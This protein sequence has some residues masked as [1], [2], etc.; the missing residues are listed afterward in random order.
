MNSFTD[1][2][3]SYGRADSRDFA[4]EVCDRLTQQGYRV[5]Y[6]FNDIPPGVDYQK[7]IHN[8]IE[9]TDNFL[10]IISP[11]ATNSPHCRAEIDYAVSLNKR[12]VPIMH[13]EEIDQE[14]WQ[15]RHPSGTID[16]WNAYTAAGKQLCYTNLHSA[17]ANINWN[18]V[19]FRPG[20]DDIEQS[21]QALIE[22]FERRRDYVHHHT[23]LLSQ[24]LEWKRNQRQTQYLLIGEERQQAEAWL[25]ERFKDE[26]A[27]CRPT[28]L[29][30][31]FIT[32]SIKNANNLMTQVFLCH[33]EKDWEVAETLRRSLMR[34]GITTWIHHNDIESASDFHTEMK[35]GV[36]E[37]DNVVFLL[38][39]ASLESEYCQKELALA[40]QLNKRI[41]PIR[42]KPVTSEQIPDCL[43]NLQYIDFVNNLTNTDYKVDENDLL[44]KL[45]ENAGFYNEHKVL[46]AKA[47][48]WE[49]QHHN[50]CILLRGYELQSAQAWLKVAKKQE[51]HDPIPLQEQFITE[52]QHQ[53][54]GLSLDIFVSYSRTDSDFAR[55]LNDELQ[56]Q[57]KRTWF[58]QESIA[59][60]ADF[61]KE[62][63]RGI[64]ASDHFLFVL[65]P[66]SVTSRYCA[67]EVEYAAKL[68][69]NIVT[70][71][72]QG[73]D[74]DK[75][76]SELSKIQWI[77][78]CANNRDFATNFQ[79]LVRTLD[80]DPEHLRF[81][82]KLLTQAIAWDE[83]KRRES[84]LLRGDEL[85]DAEQW[86][87]QATA[88]QP[89]PTKLQSLY[90]TASRQTSANRQRSTIAVLTVLLGFAALG[91]MFGFW[92]SD[93]ASRALAEANAAKELAEQEQEK[94]KQALDEANDQRLAAEAAEREAA[95]SQQAESRQRQV[96]ESERER[97]ENA[98]ERAKE[99]ELEAN[100]QAA[101]AN[102][103][104]AIAEKNE[105]AAVIASRLAE[106]SVDDARQATRSA[107]MQAELSTVRNLAASGLTFQAWLR[108][109][110]IGRD[111]QI[112]ETK[113]QQTSNARDE[114]RLK[115]SSNTAHTGA[116]NPSIRVQAIALLREIVHYSGYLPHTTLQGHSSS[117]W[118]LDISPDGQT[119]ASAS[120]DQ[121]VK[122]WDMHGQEQ[123]TLEGHLAPINRVSF[124]PN[125]QTLATGS[126]DGTVKLWTPTGEELIT[127]HAHAS[128]VYGIKFSADGQVLATAS[129]DGSVKLWDLATI[130]QY[131][132]TSLENSEHRLSPGNV[133]ERGGNP[134]YYNEHP[135][136]VQ[137]GQELSIRLE[138]NEFDTYLI[139]QNEDGEVISEN[140][141]ADSTTV[142][143]QLTLQISEDSTYTIMATSYTPE[144]TGAYTFSVTSLPKAEITLREHSASVSDID[145]SP[146]DQTFVT[147]SQDGT[148]SL[149]DRAGNL[150]H[151]FTG[152][153][154]GIW[155]V[156]F[157]PDG[158]TLAT[159]S[160]DGAVK[161][162]DVAS[163][164]ESLSFQ[165]HESSIYSI[166][167]APNG[168]T[169]A[170]ASQDGTVKLWD[171]NGNNRQT[172]R[173]HVSGV[174]E[175]RFSDDGNTLFSAGASGNIR[176]W[177]H[178]NRELK[179][180]GHHS[181]SV[182]HVSF[183]PDGQTFA[184]ASQDGIV[185]LWNQN[186]EER[187][188]LSNFYLGNIHRLS[189]SPDGQLLATASANHIIHLW[190]TT[191]LEPQDAPPLLQVEAT[192]SSAE[193]LTHAAKFY[194][195]HDFESQ[196]G[197]DITLQLTSS[198]FDTYLMVLNEAGEVIAENDDFSETH[199]QVSM[200]IAE[201]GTYTARVTSYGA[202]ETGG[203]RLNVVPTVS[204]GHILR[205]HG[206]EV[207]DVSFSPNG[208]IIASGSAYGTV[209]L[210]DRTG[211]E[212]STFRYESGRITAVS[213][214][215]DGQWLV[216][217]NEVGTVKLLNTDTIDLPPI[218][219][220]ANQQ[221][222]SGTV[223][224]N[225]GT[226]YNEHHFEAQSGQKLSI[227]LES[228]E[229]DTYLLLRNATG[230]IIA[231]DDDSGTNANSTID[232]EISED[233]I[234]TIVATSFSPETTGSY[235]LK[236]TDSIPGQ[237][238]Q[239]HSGQIT[240]V[241]FSPD[242]QTFVTASSNEDG[243]T[244]TI[245]LWNV[246]G[247]ELQ[248]F[249]GH[250]GG[251]RS[252]GFSSD[253]QIII[254]ASDDGTV[255]LWDLAGRELQTL[256]GHSNGVTSASFSP[257]GRAIAS[258][259]K[260]IILWNFDLD[261][262]MNQ[263]CDWLSDYMANSNTPPE[264]RALCPTQS[265]SA[266][267]L[268]E[269][270]T[271][272][273]MAN[274][275]R[276]WQRLFS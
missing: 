57:G 222:Q 199:S 147:A 215:P 269:A 224:A 236:V 161:L 151:P 72:Y 182:N 13:V 153:E 187:Y 15:Q 30:C 42:V 177:D 116:M 258:T 76:H 266:V 10:F 120:F 270:D 134:Y 234:Y 246:D 31:E 108:A 41:I 39:P 34:A 173:G 51:L 188:T 119:L 69:K 36:E 192:L 110:N 48:K 163:G 217:A 232:I 225:R 83:K 180:L 91:G 190:D 166:Q 263:S 207:L 105:E 90:V 12:L 45:K 221:L 193:S 160:S 5:W 272:T 107:E 21:F 174:W 259:S 19:S 94:T 219:Q 100:R 156:S 121:T 17:L 133:I 67:D 274:I 237:M 43:K 38:S 84:L 78:F 111:I 88:K 6:D 152:H 24:A 233:G 256:H 109:L 81:H 165:G 162:W 143:S 99:G 227:Q 144:K 239:T 194:N 210:W 55:K 35:R 178:V 54:P 73:V 214:S 74:E 249:E 29:H 92:K 212:R 123:C 209:K 44:R 172:L 130:H 159:A 61:Q 102:E 26:Q 271:H 241:S 25:S 169:F 132:P 189:F 32:E 125:G 145:F 230:D 148:V 155:S 196:A 136:P 255:K 213:F 103:Q 114:I 248:T 154:L 106:Q 9:R 37:A 80:T 158:T 195:D 86:L 126:E 264:E 197:Q 254:S 14:T 50:P 181:G 229:F 168:E 58:D 253:G 205:G 167:F 82:T 157:S 49:R 93:V 186:G 18:Q 142:N 201:T 223:L 275:Q 62:I 1:I 244:G 129:E 75:L 118:G 164:S 202:Q 150:V 198:E 53:P 141:D 16:H 46:L 137:A 40:S 261:D 23:V 276:F 77:D 127:L 175:L 235:T 191:S 11:H 131:Q 211:Q 179:T 216:A 115:S 171:K 203:Y 220:W 52:S 242:S 7:Q 68:N 87:I 273:L 135:L 247:A 265:G 267:S 117:V 112:L 96:A 204:S 65:S 228:D 66:K 101:I 33:S 3:I 218:R 138:S 22:I 251:V 243:T 206:N 146:N 4:K 124:S 226:F 238:I 176:R 70:V 268:P 250:F 240:D 89:S 63:Y 262:L 79:E 257:D 139:I 185:K 183:S 2:F 149:W 122:L 56:R 85:A 64:E 184:T 47:L 113:E 140:D 20:I 27:P 252:V 60:G 59:S 128:S 245:K 231:E 260:E 98:L 28:D 170:T 95:A 200:R 71:L 104:R 208:Q 97:A 8:S